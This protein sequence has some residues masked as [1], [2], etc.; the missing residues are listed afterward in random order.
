L[1]QVAEGQCKRLI[2]TAPPRTLKSLAVSV[3][4]PAWLLGHDP[5]RRIVCASYAQALADKHALDTRAVLRA[6]WYRRAFPGTRLSAEKFALAEMM[7]TA[8]GGRVATSVRGGLTGRGGD[9]LLIDDPLKIEAARSARARRAVADWFRNT[10]LSS[11]DGAPGSAIV[12]VQTRLHAEDLAGHLLAEGGWTHLNLPA[13]AECGERVMLEPGIAHARAA[14]DVLH[15]ER[16]PRET[17][18]RLAREMDADTFAACYQQRPAPVPVKRMRQPWRFEYGPS[19]ESADS[20]EVSIPPI[21]VMNDRRWVE[22][23][24]RE[25]HRAHPDRRGIACN[26]PTTARQLDHF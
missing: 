12:L 8:R 11:L 9:V 24:N 4:F 1:R 3:A 25:G 20:T 18:A 15:P 7:T 21:P 13:I 5:T 26:A 17:L 19:A 2:I 6:D 16:V 14:G 23:V 22:E 10:A